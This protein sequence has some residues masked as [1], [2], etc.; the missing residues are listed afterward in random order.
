MS[1]FN[2]FRYFLK[3]IYNTIYLAIYCIAEALFFLALY[4]TKE[5]SLSILKYFTIFN[6]I[7]YFFN[8]LANKISRQELFFISYRKKLLISSIILNFL[9]L[10]GNC[11]IYFSIY[12]LA[13][14]SNNIILDYN[15]IVDYFIFQ[16]IIFL[17]LLDI[18]VIFNSKSIIPLIIIAMGII[19]LTGPFNEYNFL[20]PN[21]EFNMVLYLNS[22]VFEILIEEVLYFLIFILISLKKNRK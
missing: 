18:Y 9:F 2:I 7:L 4:Y 17:L 10:I 12:W 22:S 14:K 3:E 20:F 11:L 5:S 19:L 6:L 8:L 13:L 15:Q 21:L 16:L 1:L